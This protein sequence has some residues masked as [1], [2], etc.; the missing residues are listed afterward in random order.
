MMD[1]YTP[2]SLIAFH[3]A[4]SIDETTRKAILNAE[5]FHTVANIARR[6]VDPDTW[7]LKRLK[8]M[9]QLVRDKF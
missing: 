5:T 2:V 1:V 6:I 8:I 9:E 7:H 3:A 4:R